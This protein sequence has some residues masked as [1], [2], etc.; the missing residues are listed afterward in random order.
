MSTGELIGTIASVFGLFTCKAALPALIR[1]I[2]VFAY[3][4]R[5]EKA[6]ARMECGND[7][8]NC[9]EDDEKREKQ[10]QTNP[11]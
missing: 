4:I 7:E 6:L 8:Y 11:Q 9:L 5:Y 1:L 2:F 3:F 10:N